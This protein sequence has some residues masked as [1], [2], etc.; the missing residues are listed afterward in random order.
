MKDSEESRIW[1]ANPLV[2]GQPTYLLSQSHIYDFN[3]YHFGGFMRVPTGCCQPAV[4][5]SASLRTHDL[6]PSWPLLYATQDWVPV[7]TF[8]KTN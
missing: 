5:F 1:I 3:V 8:N 7:L 4:N 2:I 6:P